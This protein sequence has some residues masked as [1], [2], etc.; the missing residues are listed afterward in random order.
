MIETLSAPASST[1][2]ASSTCAH[3]A[4]DRERHEH[5]VGRPARQLDDGRALVGGRRDVEEHQLVGALRVVVRGQLDRVAGVADVD[6]PRALDDAAGVDVHA[7]DDALVVHGQ[8]SGGPKK[9][10]SITC[11]PALFGSRPF[12]ASQKN[13]EPTSV[14]PSSKL[15]L[16][17]PAGRTS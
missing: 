14:W 6:E 10:S 2:C 15:S 11:R 8:S 12:S 17:V 5:V 1:A 16:I 4:A 9:V 7:G 13:V 3:A